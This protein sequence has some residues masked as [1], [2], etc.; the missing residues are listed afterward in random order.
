MSTDNSSTNKIINARS[1]PNSK[2]NRKTMNVQG[3][4]NFRLA[5]WNP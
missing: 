4:K 2:E 5:R 3:L 1:S